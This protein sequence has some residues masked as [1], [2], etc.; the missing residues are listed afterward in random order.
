MWRCRPSWGVCQFF[1]ARCGGMPVSVVVALAARVERVGGWR[2]GEKRNPDNHSTTVSA[3]VASAPVIATRHIDG[4]PSIM[5][6]LLY[7]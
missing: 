3:A 7:S 6:D 4:A 5:T 1:H 2:D